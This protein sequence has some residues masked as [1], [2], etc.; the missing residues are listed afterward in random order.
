MRGGL[1]WGGGGMLMV[2][3]AGGGGSDVSLH[4]RELCYTAGPVAEVLKMA[5]IPIVILKSFD[6]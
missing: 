5:C 4:A 2:A 6:F 3:P 1:E